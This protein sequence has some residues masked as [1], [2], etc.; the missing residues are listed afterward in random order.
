MVKKLK[1][2]IPIYG[3]FTK[4]INELS[5]V[6]SNL[7]MAIYHGFIGFIVLFSTAYL[8]INCI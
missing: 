2:F 7:M 4:E 8:T 1:M 3:M 6:E 5:S